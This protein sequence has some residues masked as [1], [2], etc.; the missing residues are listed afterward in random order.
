MTLT[1]DDSS[2]THLFD[3]LQDV[4]VHVDGLVFP[5]YFLVLDTKG[6]SGGS[7]ILGRSFLATEKALIDADTGE[8]VLKFNKEKVIFNVYDWTQ[9]VEDLDTCY[10][11][12][13]RGSKVDK[14]KE[15]SELT[16]VWVFLASDILR[17]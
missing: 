1:L 17:H 3:I 14:G 4:L 7:V 12:E 8:L 16:D 6:D 2:V 10:H 11:L 15:T 9:Y 5:T 13:E